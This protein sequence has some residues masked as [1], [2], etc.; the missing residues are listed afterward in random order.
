MHARRDAWCVVSDAG[1]RHEHKPHPAYLVVGVRAGV[2]DAVHVE[3]EV[4][5][6]GEEGE[7]G[8]DVVHAH[9]AL[10]EPAVEFRN[11]HGRR[12]FALFLCFACNGRWKGVFESNQMLAVPGQ[13]PKSMCLLSAAASNSNHHHRHSH[14]VPA[15][16]RINVEPRGSIVLAYAPTFCCFWC[17]WCCWESAATAPWEREYP[18]V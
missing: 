15:P 12:C 8:D 6:L 5:E 17:C 4:V 7:V 16:L 3:V 2:D 13:T 18:L 1:P 10:R 14:D 9:V 11:A